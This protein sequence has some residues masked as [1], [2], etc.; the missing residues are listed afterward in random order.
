MNGNRYWNDERLELLRRTIRENGKI[1]SKQC[2]DAVCA[3][4]PDRTRA[5]NYRAIWA[6]SSEVSGP[7]VKPPPREEMRARIF[8]LDPN[9]FMNRLAT[10]LTA[11]GDQLESPSETRK[12][13]SSDVHLFDSGVRVRD[14]RRCQPEALRRLRVW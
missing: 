10:L 9:Q 12:T 2:L 3:A 14:L 1:G 7:P 13:R 8:S 11:H 4:F 5:N 6:Y